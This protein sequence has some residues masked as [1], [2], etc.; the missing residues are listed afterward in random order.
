MQQKPALIRLE[1]VG[2]GGPYRSAE[3]LQKLKIIIDYLR[4]EG[5]TYQISVIPR[6][7]DPGS[8]YDKSIDMKDDPYIR[9]FNETIQY[10]S[11][12]SSP[13][14][15]HGYTHQYAQSVSG[16]GWEFHYDGCSCDCP[17]D[18]SPEACLEWEAFVHSY[19]SQRL[20]DGFNAFRK[21]PLQVGWGFSTPHYTASPNQRCI[22]EAWSGLLFETSPY[23]ANP[24]RISIYDTDNPFY[25]GVIYVPTP[26]YYIKHDQPYLEVERICREIKEYREDDL[27]AFFYH[28]PLEFPFIEIGPDGRVDYDDNSYLKMLIR[29]FQKENFTFVPL[30]SLTNFVPG[31]RTTGFYPGLENIVMTGDVT[32]NNKTGLIIWQPGTGS[33]YLEP[34]NLENFPCRQLDIM[35]KVRAGIAL[36]NWAVGDGWRPLVGDFDGDGI[37]DVVVWNCQN[38]DWQV[39]LGNGTVLTPHPGRGDGSWLKPWAIGSHWVPFVGDFNGDGLDDILVWE[40]GTGNWQVALSDGTQ[41]VPSPGRGDFIWLEP[42]AAGD[43]WVPV[44]GDFDGDGKSDIAVWNPAAGEWQVALS[45]GQQFVP[46]AGRGDYIWLGLWAI[47]TSWKPL[48]GDFDGNGRSDIVVVDAQRGDW[49]VALSTGQ[50]FVPVGGAFQ[51]WAAEPD[52]QPF[53][54]DFNGDGRWSVMARHPYL[55]D[56]T[57]DVAVSVINKAI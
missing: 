54:G 30:L 40:P 45:D 15:M 22:I 10:C 9:L 21:S 16:V 43:Y 41:F 27:A 44:V 1:D 46:N 18:D 48:V 39:A 12:C 56:G 26:L 38:G 23:G 25:R 50:E 5:V 29:C 53:A 19:A 2:P 55:R 8:G 14:G 34:T 42:W 28:A 7:V 13:I 52:M 37:A 4:S 36:S 11:D 24:R 6:F 49:Q 3:A 32:G 20:G 31:A 47:G 35:N 57:L 51:P 17:P 33:W